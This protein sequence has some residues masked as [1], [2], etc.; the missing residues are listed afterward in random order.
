MRYH[1]LI[2]T[3]KSV[4]FSSNF[5]RFPK[6]N[7][8]ERKIINKG[9]YKHGR[10]YHIY[11]TVEIFTIIWSFATIINTKIYIGVSH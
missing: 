5:Q 1:I 9:I 3:L 10:L 8:K 4:F 11:S 6:K 7:L 2:F